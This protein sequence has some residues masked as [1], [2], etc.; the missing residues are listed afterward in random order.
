MVCSPVK[1]WFLAIEKAAAAVEIESNKSNQ[2]NPQNH[3]DVTYNNQEEKL[4]NEN[5]TNLQD[6]R[7]YPILN[8]LGI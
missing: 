7:K 5:E 4:E 8:Y 2:M 1:F 6:L 3:K